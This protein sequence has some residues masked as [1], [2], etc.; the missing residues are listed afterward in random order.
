MKFRNIQ[1]LRA[2]N[3]KVS[4]IYENKISGEVIGRGLIEIDKSEFNLK[5]FYEG[6]VIFKKDIKKDSWLLDYIN[7]R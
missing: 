5:N 7:H 2:G 1:V 3:L 4:C 6:M